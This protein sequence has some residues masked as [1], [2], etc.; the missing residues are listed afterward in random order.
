VLPGSAVTAVSRRENLLDIFIVASD[1]RV[2]AAAWPDLDS[3]GPSSRWVGWW[4]LPN[5]KGTPGSP[6]HAAARSDDKLD[7]FVTDKHGEI[8][9]AAWDPASGWR[10]WRIRDRLAQG[11]FV[12]EVAA[13]S[14]VTV[15]RRDTDHLDI[16]VVGKDHR[17]YT[18]AW[19]PGF[20]HWSGWWS[21]SIVHD[22]QATPLV[23]GN[24][25][26]PVH[27]VCRR[28]NGPDNTLDVFVT[29]A[30]G[31]VHTAAWS[32]G[33]R[34]Q[35][36]LLA[37]ASYAPLLLAGAPVNAVSRSHDKLD[38]FTVGPDGRVFTAAWEPEFSGPRPWRGW[39]PLGY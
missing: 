17:V 21:L 34:W 1:E 31:R 38:L 36:D 13:G 5:I 15:A 22:G 23:Q 33:S 25:L 12:P 19:Q 29:D 26:A 11:T 8:H 32:V 6:V 39:K 9:T 4:A 14:P 37:P 16:F 35:G 10:G 24:P 7:V 20:T 27:V 18:A 3:A 30:L 28:A 2:Y